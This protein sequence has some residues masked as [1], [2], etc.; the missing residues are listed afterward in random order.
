MLQVSIVQCVCQRIFSHMSMYPIQAGLNFLCSETNYV[1][2]FNGIQKNL[3]LAFLVN[4][5]IPIPTILL[6]ILKSLVAPAKLLT[7]LANRSNL[8][9]FYNEEPIINACCFTLT[10]ILNK[11]RI[12]YMKGFI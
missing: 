6:I 9:V 11:I 1:N 12:G 7:L 2:V 4:F 5:C 10:Q 8:L 3:W